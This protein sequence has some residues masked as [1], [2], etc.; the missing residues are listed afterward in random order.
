M[1]KIETN[2]F[3]IMNLSELV[4]NYR[5]Y[6]I[7]GMGDKKSGLYFVNLNNIVR[8]LSYSLKK[9]VTTIEIEGTAHLVVRSDVTIMPTS[10]QVVKG[11]VYFDQIGDEI[12]LDFSLRSPEN[13]PICQ[14]FLHFA[15]QD[16]LH[17]HLKLWQPKAGAAFFKRKPDS[18]DDNG[19]AH[20]VGFSFRIV[21]RAG[22]LAVR[23]HVANKYVAQKPLPAVFKSDAEFERYR[24]R[25]MLY[26]FGYRWYEA[27]AETLA[28]LNVVDYIVP[29]DGATL[30]L[31]D[32]IAKHSRKPIPEDLAQ[33][34]AEGS[35][36]GY[37]GN[38]GED[39]AMPAGLCYQIFGAHDDGMGRLH[40]KSLLDAPERRN[41]TGNFVRDYFLRLKFGE[42][43]LQISTDPL[44]AEE[45]RFLMPDLLF[46]NGIRLSVRG[47]EGAIH[48]ALEEY[49]KMRLKL[50]LDRRAGFYENETL[51]RQYLM[52]PQSV[53]DSY[54]DSFIEDL[55]AAVEEL[56]PQ[57]FGF[58]PEIIPYNDRTK[59]TLGHQGNAIR[60]ALEEYNPMPGGH[61]VVMVHPVK[62]RRPTDEDELAAMAIRELE[63]YEIRGAAIH[64]ETEAASYVMGK[65]ADGNPK[66]VQRNDRRQRG[67]LKGY[68]Q[69]VALN[70][71][72]LNNGRWAFVL[73][74]RLHSDLVIGIDVKNNSA[75]ITVIGSN[76]EKLGSFTRK[77]K[78]R[79]QLTAAQICKW[80]KEIIE[81]EVLARRRKNLPPLRHIVIHRDG[82][83]FECE[84]EGAEEAIA[85]FKTAG[86]LARE[87]S[88]TIVEIP[89]N[90]M[91]PMRFFDITKKS[92]GYAEV[93]NPQIGLYEVLDET[94]GYV[95]TTGRTFPR[96]GTVEPLCVKRISGDLTME[97]CL[98]DVFYL[99]A[100]AL[101]KPDDCS[102]YP[103]SI[104]LND[105]ALTDAATE[106]D[107]DALEY[108]ESGGEEEN[109]EEDYE[110]DSDF[111]RDIRRGA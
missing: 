54:G 90:P 38:R 100:L 61:A 22:G 109:E 56:F 8:K 67:I 43:V 78:Q 41:R 63:K 7:R 25:T 18:V 30:S 58:D 24:G 14:K 85:D 93:Q 72:L 102:R 27:K 104:K 89:K 21:N 74:T 108:A 50:L 13:D 53:I 71:V 73:A 1:R 101:T 68:L 95:C 6:K 98:E 11:T 107:E 51:G 39:R 99:S 40:K 46:G 69:N 75:G 88:L 9:P 84:I 97:Q 42:T 77:S 79:E 82:R 29:D 66:Y 10:L 19:V 28:D 92:G 48:V 45:K 17:D 111:I 91:A 86:I 96:R 31:I 106:F 83:M 36:I 16:R 2:D 80:L 33:I 3:L 70:K 34:P 57:E 52:L 12:A 26:H 76:G 65:D 49:G 20:Y 64:T 5:L 15:I 87:A 103:L 60:E 94:E 23:V 32:Y 105:R 55:I 59:K 37:R 44:L 62:K 110:S 47:S 35:V 81:K 4:A